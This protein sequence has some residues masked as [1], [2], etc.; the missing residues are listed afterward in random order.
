MDAQITALIQEIQSGNEERARDLLP[1]VY[2][3]LRKLA[4]ARL[5]REKPGQTLQATALV[6][7]A[8]LRLIG[9]GANEKWNGRAH[10]FGAAAEAMRR[11]LVENARRRAAV[12]NGGGMQRIEISSELAGHCAPSCRILE[13]NEALE[14]LES[15]SPINANL[16]KLILFTGL[17][18]EDASAAVGISSATGYRKWKYARA[19]LKSALS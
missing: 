18:V 11:I 17:S 8:Y 12:V 1:V 13:L 7:E 2:D 14:Q 4:Q 9:D 10:F 5:T 19:F 6:H 16:A 15:A 3:E